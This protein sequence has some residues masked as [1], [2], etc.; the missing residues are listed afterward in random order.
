LKSQQDQAGSTCEEL[1]KFYETEGFK[2]GDYLGKTAK[3]WEQ[4]GNF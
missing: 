1:I 3:K 2:R 4:T